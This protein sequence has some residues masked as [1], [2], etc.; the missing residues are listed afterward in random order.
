MFTRI[1]VSQARRYSQL[2]LVTSDKPSIGRLRYV[3]YP[4]SS[5]ISTTSNI[6]GGC[7]GVVSVY[8]LVFFEQTLARPEQYLEEQM[9][10]AV[11]S[12]R[13]LTKFRNRAAAERQ[14]T[15]VRSLS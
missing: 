15:D 8:A 10:Y 4:A 5:H 9:S 3:G 2:H 11:L 1:R 7:V 13:S 12:S 14:V 6:T